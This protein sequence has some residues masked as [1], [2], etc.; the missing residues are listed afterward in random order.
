MDQR[1]RSRAGTGVWV[2]ALILAAPL[3]ARAATF[4]V[5]S[6]ADAVDVSPGDGVCATADGSCTLR[7]AIQEANALAG[8]D[9]VVLPAGTYLLT[10]AGAGEDG[11]ATGDLDITG[12]LIIA[13]AGAAST[14]VDGNGLDRV[15]HVDP[16]AAGI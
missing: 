1:G 5:N 7:A 8:A 3:T 2:V 13:G 15:F 16:A 10:L 6:T 9:T 14:V 4:T 11:A 12:D